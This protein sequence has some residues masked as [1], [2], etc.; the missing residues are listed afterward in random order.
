MAGTPAQGPHDSLRYKWLEANGYGRARTRMCRVRKPVTCIGFLGP[1]SE[2][3]VARGSFW[4]RGAT[5]HARP[6]ILLVPG[7]EERRA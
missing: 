2:F 6:E 5:E 4:N 1:F 3:G 7:A